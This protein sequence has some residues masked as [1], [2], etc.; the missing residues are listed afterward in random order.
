[1]L[2]LL[3]ANH[4]IVQ[5]KSHAISYSTGATNVRLFERA[6]MADTMAVLSSTERC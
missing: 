2:T 1:M 3:A 6:A 4:L 5:T